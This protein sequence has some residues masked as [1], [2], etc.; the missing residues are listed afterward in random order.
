M[1]AGTNDHLSRLSPLFLNLESA[2]LT[3][4][5]SEIW[6]AENAGNA[7]TEVLF[8]IIRISKPTQ[9]YNNFRVMILG[10]KTL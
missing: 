9:V 2:G 8:L 1:F 3:R 7:T 4:L 6:V 10:V 5:E